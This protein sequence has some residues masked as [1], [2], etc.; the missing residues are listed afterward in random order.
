MVIDFHEDGAKRKPV[1]VLG[2]DERP[3]GSGETGEVER[4]MRA[5]I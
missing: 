1:A 2:V 4:L 5:L 3:D